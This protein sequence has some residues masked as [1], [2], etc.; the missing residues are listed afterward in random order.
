MN[1]MQRGCATCSIDDSSGAA[2]FWRMTGAQSISPV[3]IIVLK[4]K[5]SR[6]ATT[7]PEFDVFHPVG[8]CLERK[9]DSP[10]Y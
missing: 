4:S 9:A 7:V 6:C 10:I 8:V 5:R 3:E 1:K 2:E